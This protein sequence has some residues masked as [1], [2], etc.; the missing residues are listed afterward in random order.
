M[1]GVDEVRAKYKHLRCMMDERM[2]RLWAATEAEAIGYGGLAAV[3][4]ATGISESRI[5]AG[6]RD[7]AEQAVRPPT[8][9]PR[10]QRIRRPGAGRPALVGTD[11]TLVL[12]LESPVD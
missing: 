9:P 2:T 11:P 6:L 5:R 12:A 7:L 10:A 1:A 4:K 8:M 3:T